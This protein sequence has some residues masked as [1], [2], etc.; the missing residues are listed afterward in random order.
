MKIKKYI[1]NIFD[2]KLF[3]NFPLVTKKN[4]TNNKLKATFSCMGWFRF[5]AFPKNIAALFLEFG[6]K[7]RI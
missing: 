6:E 5:D 3:K 7:N 1:C 2:K 4:F